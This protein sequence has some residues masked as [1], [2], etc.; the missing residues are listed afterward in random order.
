MNVLSLFDGLSGCRVAFEKAKIPVDNYFASE[1]D[2]HAILSSSCNYPDNIQLGDVNLIDYKALPKIDFLVFGSPCQGFSFA[3]KQEAFEDP[4]SALFYKALEILVYLQKKNPNLK[5]LMEN[6]K[7]KDIYSDHISDCLGVERVE[8]N[9]ALV[10]AQRRIRYYWANFEIT[11]PE[12]KGILLDHILEDGKAFNYSSSGRKE[13]GVKDRIY[14]SNKAHTVT[15]K[16]YSARSVTGVFQVNPDKSCCGKQPSIQNRVYHP[17]GKM[18]AVTRKLAD[19]LKVGLDELTWRKLTVLELERLQ[20]FP[21]YYTK[22]ICK[23]QAAFA[24]G[25]AFQVDTIVHILKCMGE[26]C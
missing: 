19:R 23:T 14:V 25:N 7:M 17:K 3:G 2:K 8:I 12:D 20:G 18:V 9:S 10:S 24:L 4:R 16:G 26:Q 1:I 5:F 13:L 15:A 11:Q 22:D 6:T 21:D